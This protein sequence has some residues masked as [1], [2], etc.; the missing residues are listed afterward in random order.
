MLHFLY[1]FFSYLYALLCHSLRPYSYYKKQPK[2]LEETEHFIPYTHPNQKP[3]WVKHRVMYLKVHLP[4][5]GWRKIA[6][7]FNQ[8]YA[9]KEVSVSKSYVYRLLITYGYEII[10]QRKEMR[11]QLPYPKKKNQLWHID[12]T[13]I[14]KR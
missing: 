1:H 14:E 10:Q 11:N 6:M 5:Y 8:M 2:K 7:Q 4:E 13:T 12:L 3:E 9:D